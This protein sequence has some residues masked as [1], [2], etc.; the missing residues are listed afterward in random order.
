MSSR[1]SN[2]IVTAFAAA[3]LASAAAAQA[4][5]VPTTVVGTVASAGALQIDGSLQP[6]RQSTVAAQVGG[7]VLQLAVKAGDRV[8]SG[9]LLARID[10]R[11]VQAG[12]NR[13]E[14]G[15]AQAEANWR[16]ARLNA[17]RLRDLRAQGF[18]SQAALDVAETQRDAAAAG[19][20]QAQAERSQ[21]ALA[22]G[23]ANV[24]APFDAI[25]Q[26]THVEV[27]DLATAGRPLVTLYAP[28]QMRA[29][30][31]LPASQSALAR[32]AQKVEVQLP[33]GRWVVPTTRTDLPT[34]DA[35]SQTVEW[36]LDLSPALSAGLLPGQAVRV[37]FEG[38]PVAAGG[39]TRLVVPP[40]AVLRRGEL[41][42]VYVVQGSQFVLKAVRLGADRGPAG[43]EV[44]AGLKAGERIALDAVRAGLAGVAVQ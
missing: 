35:V 32:A 1:T 23:F 25:V 43:V 30:V 39:A 9:Q 3:T 11:D 17:D 42:A 19:L 31:Q 14:A 16:N 24:T 6:V 12:L 21:A 44:V 37:R 13:G 18:V 20:R 10:D 7:N 26:T 29:V 33:D 28:G 22:R 8:K 40:G 38:A 4:P 5:A 15:V 36:R 2:A 27:G 34:A 41:I